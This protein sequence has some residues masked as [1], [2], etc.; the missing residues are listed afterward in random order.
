MGRELKWLVEDEII[1]QRYYET[2]TA[3]EILEGTAEINPMI[4]GS[5]RQMVHVV[6]QMDGVNT[7]TKNVKKLADACMPLFNNK[8]IGWFIVYG[9]MN[10]FVRFLGESITQMFGVR[11]RAFDTLEESLDFLQTRDAE[12]HIP[13]DLPV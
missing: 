2:M 13:E 10:R 11:Y 12:L 4:N 8:K 3:D 5:P 1:H 6:M 9:D 7:I